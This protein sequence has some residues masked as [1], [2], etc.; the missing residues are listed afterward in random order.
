[1]ILVL[2][3]PASKT[4]ISLVELVS[5]RTD[6]GEMFVL[7]VVKFKINLFSSFV[8]MIQTLSSVPLDL[9][10]ETTSCLIKQ[11]LVL[12]PTMTG[13]LYAAKTVSRKT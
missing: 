7:A 1:M 12:N 3:Y 9:Q 5:L 10:K 4:Y 8:S 11:H 2:I 13:F 6:P